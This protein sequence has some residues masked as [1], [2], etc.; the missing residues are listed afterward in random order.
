[1]SNKYV[2]LVEQ[3]NKHLNES[4]INIEGDKQEYD[5]ALTKYYEFLDNTDETSS[6]LQSEMLLIGNTLKDQG[7]VFKKYDGDTDENHIIENP[8]P[9]EVK[10]SLMDILNGYIESVY[11]DAGFNLFGEYSKGGLYSPPEQPQIEEFK[12]NRVGWVT[13]DDSDYKGKTFYIPLESKF[14]KLLE[15]EILNDVETNF[16]KYYDEYLNDI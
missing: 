4:H 3:T 11:V 7:F 8:T 6:E 2:N 16:S 9:S 14:S 5:N 13:S 15:T 1:M 12:L 10:N